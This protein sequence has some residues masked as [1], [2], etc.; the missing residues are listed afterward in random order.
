[1]FLYFG[2]NLNE[3]DLCKI[4]A[5]QHKLNGQII[6][7]KK[8]DYYAQLPYFVFETPDKEQ[9]VLPHDSCFETL[10]YRYSLEYLLNLAL[11]TN[12]KEWFDELVY[13]LEYETQ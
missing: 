7:F 13:K 4:T 1:M 3:G 9:V 11:Q 5:P 8:V 6:K 10:P 12:D 2:I